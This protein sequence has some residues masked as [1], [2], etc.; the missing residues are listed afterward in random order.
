[1]LQT[2]ILIVMVIVALAIIG[3]IL[4]QQGKGADMGA[5]F[6]SGA[7]NTVF[8]SAGS[9]NFLSHTT[10]I[11]A[12]VFFT[13]CLVLAWFS[14]H[15]GNRAGTIDFSSPETEVQ[16]KEIPAPSDVPAVPVAPSGAGDVPAAPV[17]VEVPVA[18]ES[19]SAASSTTEAAKPA[20]GAAP[21]ETEKSQ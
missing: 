3:L 21:E 16:L 13:C 19:A 9:G 15:S 10:A 7:S 20:A 6:G 2:A 17:T 5:S 12:A 8:G 1:M 18:P 11:L 4:I 14:N